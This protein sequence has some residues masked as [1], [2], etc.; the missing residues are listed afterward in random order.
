MVNPTKD[1]KKDGKYILSKTKPPRF[2]GSPCNCVPGKRK[3]TVLCSEFSEDERRRLFKHF[4]SMDWSQRRVYVSATV[5]RREASSANGSAATRKKNSVKYYLTSESVPKRAC[6]EMYLSTLNIGEWSVHSWVK[7]GVEGMHANTIA[8]NLSPPQQISASKT[9]VIN[10]LQTLP[11]MPSHYCRAS[12]S[13]LYLEPMFQ[14]M[15]GLY[16]QYCLKLSEDSM[17]PKLKCC[18]MKVFR[19]VFHELNLF[20][21]SPKKDQCDLCCQHEAGNLDSSLY[22]NHCLRKKCTRN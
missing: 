20:L 19:D 18:S 11:K 9:F 3:K 13:K 1:E 16:R 21:C 15:A 12:S 7:Q 10:Y 17:G 8:A 4:W 5:K 6:K 2:V 22:Q 14:N